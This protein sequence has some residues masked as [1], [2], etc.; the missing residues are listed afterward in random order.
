MTTVASSTY[1]E[2]P[3]HFGPWMRQRTRWLKGYTLTWWIHACRPRRLLA[4]LGT[5][6]FVA[7]NAIVAGVPLSA[8]T[9]PI[10]MADLAWHLPEMW[11][12]GLAAVARPLAYVDAAD[13]ALGFG[14]AA[15]LAAAGIRRRR[16]DGYLGT[17]LWLPVYWLLSSFAAYRALFQL[18]AAPHLWEKTEH[19]LAR[20]SR[21]KRQ[22]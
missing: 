16:L 8:L 17:I 19:G 12:A 5:I 3:N 1:E 4:E 21:R 18:A 20:S 15:W 7:L 9:L 14:A 6:R 22:E 2:A 13:L 11:D 10:L